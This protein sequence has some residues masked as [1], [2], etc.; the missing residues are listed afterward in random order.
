V[1]AV[2]G[3]IAFGQSPSNIITF[4]APN[5]GTKRNQ[6]TFP[7]GMNS[8]GVIA[9]TVVYPNN[10]SSGFIRQV[11]GSMTIV[12][13]PGSQATTI[14]SINDAGTVA[15]MFYTTDI[16]YYHGFIRTADGKFTYFLPPGTQFLLAAQI[17]DLGNVAGYITSQYDFDVCYIRTADGTI[18]TFTPTGGFGCQTNGIFAGTVSGTYG[19]GVAS[20]TGFLRHPDGSFT[21]FL[22]G[23]YVNAVDVNEDGTTTGETHLPNS[24]PY[25]GFVRGADG[26]VSYFA[27]PEATTTV[28]FSI[29]SVGA[30]TGS[31]KIGTYSPTHG[32]Q[33]SPNGSIDTFDAP[34][35]GTFP[36]QGTSPVKINDAGSITGTFTDSKNV[37]HGFLL[38]P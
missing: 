22:V 1:F 16:N 9:G 26:A 6:G 29:N 33:R 10:Q 3:D 7:W 19:S 30:V 4:D 21:E 36:F 37:V 20:S 35:A 12:R 38:T 15:G 34:G 31:Y 32:F 25:F 18:T 8:Q 17:D 27:V 2:G 5:A 23:D 28:G 11:D 24:T 14:Q 13:V